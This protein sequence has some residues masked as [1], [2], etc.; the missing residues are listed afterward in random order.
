MPKKQVG[1]YNIADHVMQEISPFI[2]IPTTSS[3]FRKYA[4]LN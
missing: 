1:L 2:F 3:L 4:S